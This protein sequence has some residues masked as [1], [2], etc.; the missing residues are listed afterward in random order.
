MIGWMGS[1]E[2]RMSALAESSRGVQQEQAS[3]RTNNDELK[4][5]ID[6]ISDTVTQISVGVA[7]L[8]RDVAH[9]SE[10]QAK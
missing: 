4:K 1:I 6:K 2:S 8:Q 9:L 7:A 5:S 3:L 10:K